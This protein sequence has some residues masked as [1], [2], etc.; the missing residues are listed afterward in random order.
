MLAAHRSVRELV[1]IGAYVAG[2]DAD[3]DAALERLPR[4]EAFL[5]QTMDD[6]TPTPET[7]R[8]LEELVA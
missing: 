1:E 5:R 7:W 6:L 2:A 3:A 8:R 4:I